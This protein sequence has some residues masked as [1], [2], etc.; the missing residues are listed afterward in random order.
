[1]ILRLDDE[2]YRQLETA[3]RDSG[4]AVVTQWCIA[5]L[6]EIVHAA[7]PWRR[8][9]ARS[10]GDCILQIVPPYGR[11]VRREEMDCVWAVLGEEYCCADFLNRDGTS[12]LVVERDVDD[13]EIAR[14]NL[15]LGHPP[16]DVPKYEPLVFYGCRCRRCDHRWIP[17][18]LQQPDH[19]EDAP[20]DTRVGPLH[21][22]PRCK[23]PY[24]DRSRRRGE[25]KD[26]HGQT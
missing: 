12:T 20:D 9:V 16:V 3:T 13:D 5:R 1:V 14:I 10:A 24:W 8:A 15:A 25:S 22:C 23:S 4:I 17:R 19:V 26:G 21:V 18:G 7:R 11:A 2:I 6:V